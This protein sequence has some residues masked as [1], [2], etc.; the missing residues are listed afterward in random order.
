M[1]VSRFN[2]CA[3]KRGALKICDAVLY[4]ETW[5]RSFFKVV[6]NASCVQKY[7]CA[8]Y[9]CRNVFPWRRHPT[10][11]TSLNIIYSLGLRCIFDCASASWYQKRNG[12]SKPAWLVITTSNVTWVHIERSL[13]L[14]ALLKLTWVAGNFFVVLWIIEIIESCVSIL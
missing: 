3:L 7:D 9:S 12:T 11:I 14:A 10:G 1:S 13:I 8:V 5:S 2:S 4:Y 6:H